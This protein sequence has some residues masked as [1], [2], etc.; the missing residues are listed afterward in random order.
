M[1]II[2]MLVKLKINR[3]L[4]RRLLSELG[5]TEIVPFALLLPIALLLFAA[6]VDFTRIP[7]VEERMLTSLQRAAYATESALALAEPTE[8]VDTYMPAGN[9]F[10]GV[11]GS[12]CD[13]SAWTGQHAILTDALAS[14]LVHQAC[15]Q[16]LNTFADLEQSFLT[17]NGLSQD[18]AAQFTILKQAT[19]GSLSIVAKSD[20]DCLE[21]G[22]SF[23]DYSS[24]EGL[25]ASVVRTA[26]EALLQSFTDST[27]LWPVPNDSGVN[28][29]YVTGAPANLPSY[30]LLGIGYAK[31][32]RLVIDTFGEH[33]VIAQYFIRPLNNPAGIQDISLAS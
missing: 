7:L 6:V 5:F 33:K 20:D 22:A 17:L 30:W 21:D 16:A 4:Q 10:C 12:D 15:V 18:R 26:M 1:R 14:K 11:S 31:V 24:S 27:E 23:S 29:T 3:L 13:P 19:D 9:V 8:V 28:G 32:S 25:D 2:I